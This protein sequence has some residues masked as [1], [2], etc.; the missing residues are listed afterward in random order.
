M[1]QWGQLKI[2]KHASHSHDFVE[3]PPHFVQQQ[4]SSIVVKKSPQSWFISCP[5]HSEKDASLSVIV[6]YGHSKPVGFW[7]CFG[8]GEGS[9]SWDVLAKKL[10]LAL[11][12]GFRLDLEEEVT[13]NF[14]N[15]QKS[16]VK[17]VKNKPWP[18]D[19]KWRGFSGKVIRKHGGVLDCENQLYPLVFPCRTYSGEKIVGTI[20]CRAKKHKKYLSYVHSKGAWLT[21]YLWPEHITYKSRIIFIV[22]GERDALALRCLGYNALAALG[23]QSGM[24]QARLNTLHALGAEI[25]VLCMDNDEAGYKA[26]YGTYT[27]DGK[28]K[29]E[30]MIRLLSDDFKVVVFPIWDM[31]PKEVFG[32]VDMFQL[33]KQK[34]FKSF[35][36]SFLKSRKITNGF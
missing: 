9:Y 15:Q 35:F 6:D 10:N 17:L 29:R 16:A 26:A 2:E 5:F 14:F 11:V 19:R 24:N 36:K 1:A 22:E 34:K 32:K 20:T 18:I 30:G 4:L 13:V 25:I 28:V 21:S 8:C 23:T 12:D 33:A 7:K 27:D 3:P 31:F